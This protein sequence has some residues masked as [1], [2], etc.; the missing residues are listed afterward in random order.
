MQTQFNQTQETNN[1]MFKLLRTFIITIILFMCFM[2]KSQTSNSKLF[3]VKTGILD[4]LA[5]SYPLNPDYS[6]NSK[7]DKVKLD[8]N[9]LFEEED[10]EAKKERGRKLTDKLVKQIKESKDYDYISRG[11]ENMVRESSIKDQGAIY[12][13]RSN[14]YD[15][16]YRTYQYRNY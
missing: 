12:K 10:K 4:S 13:M 7:S 5:L 6:V 9:K 3:P 15:G 2:G 8:F 1:F 16:I 14:Y 11:F